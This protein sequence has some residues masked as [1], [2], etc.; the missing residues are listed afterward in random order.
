M[1]TCGTL[2]CGHSNEE[3]QGGGLKTKVGEILEIKA[4]AMQTTAR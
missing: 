4:A 3:V 2:V 1:S